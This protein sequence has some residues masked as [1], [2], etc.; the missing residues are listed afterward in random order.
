MKY[1]TP[2]TQL[3]QKHN[4]DRSDDLRHTYKSDKSADTAGKIKIDNL[5][6]PEEEKAKCKKWC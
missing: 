5:L 4:P 3:P 6:K 1:N 2:K